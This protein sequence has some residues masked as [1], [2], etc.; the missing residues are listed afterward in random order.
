[1]N[2]FKQ[3]MAQQA[4]VGRPPNQAAFK[5]IDIVNAFAHIDTSAK[6]ILIEIRD[7][8]RIEI[9]AIVTGKDVP[10]EERPIS[11][12]RLNHRAR[13]E[14]CITGTDFAC[15]G[16]ELSVIERMGQ[17]ANQPVG[18]FIGQHRVGI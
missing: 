5:G 9:E 8:Q 4:I 7:G 2:T 12:I 14:D 6:E 16:S 3:V 18:A 15:L 11:A 10:G 1:M 17:G 13:L